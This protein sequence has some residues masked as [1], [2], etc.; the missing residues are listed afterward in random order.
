MLS[1]QY[2]VCTLPKKD[3]IHKGSVRKNFLVRDSNS[4]DSEEAVEGDEENA[5]ED[6]M[7][8]QSFC[9]NIATK[10]RRAE[11]SQGMNAANSPGEG[12]L[13]RQE[14]SPRAKTKLVYGVDSR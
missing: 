13:R 9:S 1:Q 14:V 6:W 4:G 10:M 2:L 11:T 3:N 12:P 8:S 7:R 5:I